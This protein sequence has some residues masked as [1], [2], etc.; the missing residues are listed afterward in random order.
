MGKGTRSAWG[1]VG[2]LLLPLL[3]CGGPLLFAL[4][5]ATSLGAVFAGTG[6]AWLLGGVLLALALVA[7]GIL[8]RRMRHHAACDFNCCS[9]AS[10]ASKENKIGR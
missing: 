5:G 2:I 3:C 8:V 10:N 6:R 4:L 1:I 9:P 7:G